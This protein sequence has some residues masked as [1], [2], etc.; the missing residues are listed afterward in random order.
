MPQ[1]TDQHYILSLQSLPEL[2]Y[3]CKTLKRKT[4]TCVDV[5]EPGLLQLFLF[6]ARVLCL[7]R[8]DVGAHALQHH[9]VDGRLVL[10]PSRT[11]RP[12][13]QLSHVFCCESSG[14][15]SGLQ[16]RWKTREH[17]KWNSDRTNS[18]RIGKDLPGL[19]WQR[20]ATLSSY[21]H[22]S[23]RSPLFWHCQ[24]LDYSYNINH[25]M[26]HLVHLINS[27]VQQN[28]NHGAGVTFGTSQAAI[29][30]L[31]SG[32]WL[33]KIIRHRPLRCFWYL[34]I[35][36]AR[37]PPGG[38]RQPRAVTIESSSSMSASSSLSHPWSAR[39]Y[40]GKNIMP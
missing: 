12:G 25:Y 27:C 26:K 24:D 20:W 33:W 29:L 38:P 9:A 28:R 21:L 39:L 32:F 8:A 35:S 2:I 6:D 19:G 31:L 36:G 18:D 14:P 37:S 15:L 5:Q 16:G 40:I 1:H 11:H 34:W 13:T 23:V 22:Y 30:N 3:N 17:P 4:C 7:Q 10:G